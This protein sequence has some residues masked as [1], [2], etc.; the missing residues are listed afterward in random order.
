MPKKEPTLNLFK[1]RNT[2]VIGLEEIYV[3]EDF[4]VRKNITFES[5]RELA[6]SIDEN[7]LDQPIVVQ[8]WDGAKPFRVVAGHRRIKAHELLGLEEIECF[9]KDDLTEEEAIEINLRENLQRKQ[10]SVIEEARYVTMR[11]EQGWNAKTIAARIGKSA[12]WVNVRLKVLS[13]PDWIL[14]KIADDVFTN[15]EIAKLVN[16]PEPTFLAREFLG[17][18]ERKVK[19]G[20]ARQKHDVNSLKR[21]LLEQ[22]FSPH[23]VRILSWVE[24]GELDI[25]EDLEWL[26]ARKGALQ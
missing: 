8:R 24:K 14:D 10:L 19:K 26:Q 21:D 9:V 3:D 11:A 15:T 13:L 6:E 23:L 18:K 20:T 25:T 2:S 5:V 12:Q 7:G 17:R 1:G 4:N 22:G 16:S